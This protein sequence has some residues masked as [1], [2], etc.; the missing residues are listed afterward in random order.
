MNIKLTHF[1][2]YAC[3]LSIPLVSFA[4]KTTE[5]NTLASSA[6]GPSFFKGD[7]EFRLVP[8]AIAVPSAALRNS[9]PLSRGVNSATSASDSVKDVAQVGDYVIILPSA[10]SAIKSRAQDLTADNTLP[11]DAPYAVAVSESSG[12]PVLVRP[13]VTV[14]SPVATAKDLAN[15]TGGEVIY[16]SELASRTVIRYADVDS[17][18]NALATLTGNSSVTAT[19]DIIENFKKPL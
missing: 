16:S 6:T 15:K 9:E 17:A 1:V 19:L 13:S 11:Q 18:I 4:A 14:F 2:M 3:F 8:G 10:S 5:S 12:L 7:S